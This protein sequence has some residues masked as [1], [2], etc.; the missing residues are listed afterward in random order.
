MLATLVA[1]PVVLAPLAA[2][3][4]PAPKLT[5]RAR[6]GQVASDQGRLTALP[7]TQC[8]GALRTGADL[9]AAMTSGGLERSYRLHLPETVR[10]GQPVPL[11]INLHAL[12][13][14]GAIQEELSGMRPISDREGFILVSPDGLGEPRGWNAFLNETSNVDDVQFISDLIDE[15]EQNY[16]IDTRRIYVTGF[17]SGAMLASRV[18]C[19]LG[20]R[21]AAVAPVAG[22]YAPTDHC[23]G[24]APMLAIHGTMD[25]VVPF[26]G[27][28]AV[29][30][31]YPGARAAVDEWAGRIARC[32]AGVRQTPIG[33]GL[34]LE[35]HLG[36]GN[37]PASLL[38]IEGLGHAP[39][40]GATAE[41]IWSFFESHKLRYGPSY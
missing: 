4:Q 12:A 8:A 3:A 27:G 37:Q 17:S 41:F 36:C 13:S 6:V 22:V 26:A 14:S 25:T 39:P 34:T 30:A 29:G 33:A 1:L 31:A 21:V 5:P 20:T 19:R 9:V 23:V 7:G 32:S 10:Q 35:E 15:L 18:G 28:M 16:C 40:N 38:I 24:V 11:V 2:T